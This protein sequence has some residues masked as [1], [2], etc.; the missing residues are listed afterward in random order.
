[1][2]SVAA[3]RWKLSEQPDPVASQTLVGSLSIPATLADLLVQRGFDSVE[4]AKTF[5]RPTLESLSDPYQLK[6]LPEA[7]SLVAE[8]VRSGKTIVVHGDY[9][10]DGQAA[11]ALLTRVLQAAGADVRPFVPHRVRDGYD[12]S[13]A[14]VSFAEQNGASLIVT[15]DCGTTAH[16]AIAEAK[17]R[18]IAV[19]VTDHHVTGELPPADAIV[20][21]NRPDCPSVSKQLCGAGV[22]FKL[23]QALVTEL[24]LP[25]NLP[26]HLLDLVALATVADIVPLTGE[27]RTLVR[28]GLKTLARSRWPGVRALIAAA[29]LAGKPIRAGHVGFIL[30]PRLNAVG[31]IGDAKDGLSLLL[32]DDESS[33]YERAHRLEALNARR[34]AMD[35]EILREVM[36]EIDTS[37]DLDSTFGLVLANQ[38]WHPGV[39]GI[40]ASRVVERYARPTILVAVE[41][42]EGKGSGRSVSRFDL[43]AALTAC[44]S[45]LVKFGGHP[46]AA[47]LTIATKDI[48]GFRE[49][50]N[51][52]ARAQLTMDDLVTTQRVDIVA[53]MERFDA[54]LE[55]LL[56]HLEPCGAGNRAPVFAV[57]SAR[58]TNA[59]EVGQ[60]HLKFDL[61]DDTGRLK[62]IGFNLADRVPTSWLAGQVDVAFRLEEN[63]YRGEVSLQARVLDLRPAG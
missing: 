14:G 12:L 6:D 7:A 48:E 62:A 27:N 46:M 41:G 34:Q 30:A 60:N 3:T 31:R 8:T 61:Q 2:T 1:M 4:N 20:N 15:C 22:A 38:G 44:E 35:Q 19:V 42:G 43:H 9:D 13:L 24:D 54:E 17:A 36:E 11:T 23:A 39:I 16:D 53:P 45:H 28:F 63:E 50:F 5:L 37:V 32:T 33:A 25:E 58:A 57:Q 40:V 18:G 59:R 26:L 52:T 47:G 55:H 49:A 29:D 56:R 51:D 21:P 10:V